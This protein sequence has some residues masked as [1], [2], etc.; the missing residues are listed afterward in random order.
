M[1]ALANRRGQPI[2]TKRPHLTTDSD[3]TARY[4]HRSWK[5]SVEQ[6]H[7]FNDWYNFWIFFVW[8]KKK[9]L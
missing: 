6:W 7:Y 1:A 4:L 3:S 5:W 9:S 2:K 8:S